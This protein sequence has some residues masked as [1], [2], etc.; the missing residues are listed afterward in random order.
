MAADMRND[1]ATEKIKQYK[2]DAHACMRACMHA[3]TQRLVS[4]FDRSKCRCTLVCPLFLYPKRATQGSHAKLTVSRVPNA[5]QPPRHARPAH[6]P[7]HERR[8]GMRARRSGT[9]LSGGCAVVWTPK[10]E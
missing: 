10:N 5:R 1:A 6:V 8:T 9:Q 7:R 4:S 2:V 3:C